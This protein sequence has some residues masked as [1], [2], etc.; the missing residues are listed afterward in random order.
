MIWD[1]ISTEI[2]KFQDYFALIDDKIALV[3]M[4]QV[5]SEVVKEYLQKKPINK[6]QNTI[7]FMSQTSNSI[8]ST[9]GVKNRFTIII[10]AK[11][12]VKKHDLLSKVLNKTKQMEE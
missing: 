9:L 5:K 3:T 1:L 2:A 8:L 11:K 12:F 6:A 10:W 4:A 7:N